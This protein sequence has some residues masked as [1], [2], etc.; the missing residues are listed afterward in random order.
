MTTSITC[1]ILEDEAQARNLLERYVNKV[2]GLRLVARF[3]N[4]NDAQQYLL[5][6]D[7]ALL[8]ADIKLPDMNALTLLKS[9]P[10]RPNVIFCTGH[11]NVHYA[12][13][14]YRLNVVDYL[15]KPLVYDQFVDAI[16]K[17]R[18]KLGLQLRQGGQLTGSISLD[19]HGGPKK[20]FLADIV[21]IESVRNYVNIY[22]VNGKPLKVRYTLREMIEM[23]PCQHFI[24][25]H[26]SY[27]VS[28][29]MAMS[30]NRKEVH[31]RNCVPALPLGY[32]YR[33][34]VKKAIAEY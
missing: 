22:F 24:Q 18:E 12:T 26:K 8:I 17:V 14:A 7:V 28:L 15:T 20:V 29:R 23:L 30:C 4:G 19:Y 25:I 34:F 27:V 21:Y 3:D 16:S 11:N 13:Q 5:N 9:L 6:N 32:S 10:N 31:V 2:G 1:V 33:E